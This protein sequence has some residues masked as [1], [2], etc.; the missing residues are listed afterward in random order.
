MLTI[1][2]TIYFDHFWV[3]ISENMTKPLRVDIEFNYLFITFR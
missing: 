1:L 3:L 2:L